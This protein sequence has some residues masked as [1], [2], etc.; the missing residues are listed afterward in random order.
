MA[1]T[2]KVITRSLKKGTAI[3]L[4]AAPLTGFFISIHR[5]KTNKRKAILQMNVNFDKKL[6]KRISS[7]VIS[8][9]IF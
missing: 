2:P 1:Q 4:S 6:N 7:I 8:K 5:K 3:T 9:A